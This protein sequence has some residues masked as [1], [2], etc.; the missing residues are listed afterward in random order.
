LH[1]DHHHGLVE[2]FEAYDV[3]AIFVNL[4]HHVFYKNVG[5]SLLLDLRGEYVLQLINS[6]FTVTILIKKIKY[7]FN[8]VLI[9]KSLLADSSLEEFVK[10]NL[11]IAIKVDPGEQF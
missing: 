3:V 1:E 5:I 10:V 2:F 7:L 4:R 6:N 11:S 8:V 9:H